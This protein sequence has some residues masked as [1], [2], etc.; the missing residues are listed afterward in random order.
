MVRTQRVMISVS[1]KGRKALERLAIATGKPMSTVAGELIEEAAPMLE[2]LASAA[3]SVKAKKADAYQSVSQALAETQLRS[4]QLAVDFHNS[5][6]PT[7]RP[8]GRK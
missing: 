1:P 3:E 4:A 2:A 7:R 6:V 5:C 8:K